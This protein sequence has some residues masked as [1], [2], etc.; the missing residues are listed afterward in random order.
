MIS[1]SERELET[2]LSRTRRYSSRGSGEDSPAASET[3]LKAVGRKVLGFTEIDSVKEFVKEGHKRQDS[4]P[5]EAVWSDEEI[6]I[7]D[8]A[9]EQR[10]RRESGADQAEIVALWTGVNGE[11]DQPQHPHTLFRS[12]S[13]EMDIQWSVPPLLCEYKFTEKRKCRS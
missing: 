3:E 13:L 11:N 5:G 6:L 1:R 7:Q 8:D 2:M 4:I 9:C 12:Q 10:E